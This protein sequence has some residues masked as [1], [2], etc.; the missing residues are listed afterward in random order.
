M[1]CCPLHVMPVPVLR[2][3][4]AKVMG[5]F[6]LL[7]VEVICKIIVCYAVTTDA[8]P[9]CLQGTVSRVCHDDQELH[10]DCQ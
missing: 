5:L 8:V 1:V 2:S 3:A 7:C 9:L 6:T 4:D 10:S